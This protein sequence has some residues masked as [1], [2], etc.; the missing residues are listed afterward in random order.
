MQLH[1]PYGFGDREVRTDYQFLRWTRSLDQDQA[2]YLQFSPDHYDSDED[3][4]LLVSDW[5][6]VD[7]SPVPLITDG[8]PDQN[9]SFNHFNVEGDRYNLELQHDLRPHDDLRLAWGA[10]YRWDRW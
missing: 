4:R 2:F 5:F 10:G 9:F 8:E 1:F 3:S 6:G 7:P